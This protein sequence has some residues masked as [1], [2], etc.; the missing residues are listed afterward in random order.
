MYHL[1][2]KTRHNRTFKNQ[3]PRNN[4]HIKNKLI[5]NISQGE[6][7]KNSIRVTQEFFMQMHLLW[8]FSLY[9]DMIH[10]K[11]IIEHKFGTNIL[12][13]DTLFNITD[14]NFI[15]CLFS[16]K[17]ENTLRWIYQGVFMY[18]T[19]LRTYTSTYKSNSVIR[20]DNNLI[21]LLSYSVI[22]SLLTTVLA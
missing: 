19:I 20:S 7:F 11:L 14:F 18:R 9:Q 10:K 4:L 12:Y 1:I 2:D 22:M 13:K 8:N 5:V 3:E 17:R 21:I 16:A 15:S 6:F